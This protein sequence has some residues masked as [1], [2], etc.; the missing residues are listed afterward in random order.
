MRRHGSEVSFLLQEKW[1]HFHGLQRLFCISDGDGCSLLNER[2]GGF[3]TV[4]HMRYIVHHV[5][6][7][8]TTLSLR[9]IPMLAS[10][11]RQA[12]IWFP[13]ILLSKDLPLISSPLHDICFLIAKSL[14]NQGNVEL[15]EPQ[16]LKRLMEMS[17]QAVPLLRDEDLDFTNDLQL[18][19]S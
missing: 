1:L 4:I 8:I 12:D 13:F 3:N 16:S 18:S 5:S 2:L 9:S 17:R 15:P 10:R 14:G 11:W 19:C 7:T 6:D